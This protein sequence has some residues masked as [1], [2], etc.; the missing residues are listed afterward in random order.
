MKQTKIPLIAALAHFI[1]VLIVVWLSSHAGKGNEGLFVFNIIDLPV[2]IISGAVVH[3]LL[4]VN[5]PASTETFIFYNRVVTILFLTLGTAWIY[6]LTTV[7]CK[8]LKSFR[9]DKPR[10]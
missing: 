6:F 7:A 3:L 10:L 5:P 9:D 2:S 1:A 4:K 8:I